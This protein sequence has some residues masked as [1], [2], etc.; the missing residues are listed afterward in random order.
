MRSLTISIL[1][2]VCLGLLSCEKVID[3]DIRDADAKIVIEGVITDEPNSLKVTLTRTI[4]YSS[5]N[6]F[7][8]VTGAT[9]K[10]KD[11]G[12]EYTLNEVL[13]GIYENI[14]VRGR[15]G[16]LY[17]L[18]VT[19]GTET[20]TA[21]STMQV[22]VPIDTVIIG[23]GPF[24]QHKFASVYYADPAGINNGYRF[25]QYV[26]GR[27]DQAIF[28]DNDEFT[29]GQT[30]AVRLDNGVD[31]DSDPRAIHTGD[32]VKIEL[33][34]LDDVIYRFWS[35]LQMGGADGGGFTASPANPVTN[36]K[37]GALGYFSAH[38]IRQMTVIAP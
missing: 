29:D 37:G 38:A 25:I 31:S 17:E 24:G 28:W 15:V 3:V 23:R 30:T 22:P 11:N 18:S 36:I 10:I 1:L 26:N 35:T 12:V 27:K 21:S 9:V 16:H 19:T 4:K 2:V 8:A 13:P 5:S 6:Q 32:I 20:F 14:M 33:L 7:P 34:S